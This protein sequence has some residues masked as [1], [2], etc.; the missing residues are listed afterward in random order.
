MLDANQVQLSVPA[1]VSW[2]SVV[3]IAEVGGMTKQS[4]T[5]GAMRVR[6]TRRSTFYLAGY[7]PEIATNAD[8]PVPQEANSDAELLAAIFSGTGELTVRV[9][10]L[11]PYYFPIQ[12][13]DVVTV[14]ASDL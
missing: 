11:K 7:T 3:T 10:D 13:L 8:I 12:Q 9:D 4:Y 5:P 14:N 1:S 6:C 2:A